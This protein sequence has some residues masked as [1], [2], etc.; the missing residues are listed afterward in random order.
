MSEPAP[1]QQATKAEASDYLRKLRDDAVYFAETL[2]RDFA[3]PRKPLKLFW[4]QKKILR[5]K[6]NRILL[7]ISRQ[8]G[9]S[10]I[11]IIMAIH[12]AVTNHNRQILIISRS[13]EQSS[14]LLRKLTKVVMDSELKADVVLN[15]TTKLSFKNGSLIAS[16]PT[17]EATI[18]GYAP[19]LVI[20]DEAA[21]FPDDEL[22]A[23]VRP[24]LAATHGRLVLMSTPKGKRGFFWNMFNKWCEQVDAEV[25]NM[26]YI[27]TASAVEL[28][29]LDPSLVGTITCP[30]HDLEFYDIEREQMTSIKFKQEYESRF[31][32]ESDAWF[33]YEMFM[34]LM[35]DNILKYDGDPE[36]EYFIGIDW[37]Q[38]A[39]STVVAVVEREEISNKTY[40]KVIVLKE[41]FQ[42][43]HSVSM[44]YIYDINSRFN[45]SGGLSDLG[46]GR[47]QTEELE[48]KG[49]Q[50]E[51]I[52]LSQQ[53]KIDILSCMRKL[54]EQ[55]ALELPKNE[56]LE[57]QLHS[58]SY[59][60]GKSGRYLLHHSKGEHDD[61]V[62][63]IGLALWAA[64]NKRTGTGA[65]FRMPSV[66]R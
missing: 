58:F 54:M 7:N 14:D 15:S 63:A 28:Y 5:S 62:D 21:M 48:D 64:Q 44:D 25:F 32:D 65:S 59:S 6:A 18:R 40:F 47:A 4:Y 42:S 55:R 38:V 3:D 30:L 24:M 50:I 16:L 2:L 8:T 33:P 45:I 13:Q 11:A 35:R 52:A 41:F 12:H 49:M 10:S 39:D 43:K 29:G 1:F 9:K 51:G 57:R 26:P 36:K 27:I 60:I 17:S 34:P 22:F 23:A 37:G 46:G 20:L 66:L 61:M 19:H 56:K 31:V 53:S